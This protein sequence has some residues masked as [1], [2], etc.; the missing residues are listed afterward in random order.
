MRIYE[1]MF[2]VD[3]NAPDEAIDS[4][5]AQVEGV[6]RDA[7]G[8]VDKIDKWGKRKLAYRVRRREE[9]YYVVIRYSVPRTEAVKEIERRLK[10]HELVL[11]YLTVRMDEKLKWLE[12]R[13]KAR[14]KRALKKPAPAAAGVRMPGEPAPVSPGEPAPASEEEGVR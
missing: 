14:E 5:I 9:G 2:I 12:K 6:I 7:G 13:K 10:V 1:I 3:P 4:I 11:K 8:S